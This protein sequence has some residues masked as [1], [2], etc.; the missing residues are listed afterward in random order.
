M[1]LNELFDPALEGYQD[2]EDDHG[3]NRKLSDLRKT[4]LTLR[5]LNKLRR[6]NDIRTYEKSQK[7]EKVKRQYSQ[8]AE[9]GGMPN[10]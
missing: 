10:L 3:S 4:K 1:I 2:L 9:E 7:L 6:M 8:P 5:Q